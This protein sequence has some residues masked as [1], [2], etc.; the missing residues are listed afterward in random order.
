MSDEVVTKD[1]L[2]Y[3]ADILVDE[4]AQNAAVASDT[5]RRVRVFELTG[6]SAQSAQQDVANLIG[7]AC[8]RA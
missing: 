2:F 1:L 7:G 4:L 6:P 5:K 8:Y 3:V